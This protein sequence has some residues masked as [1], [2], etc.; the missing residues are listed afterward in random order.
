MLESPAGIL[1]H[2]RGS[3]FSLGPDSP[4]D[5]ASGKRPAHTLMPVTVTEGDRLAWVAGA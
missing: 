4:D 3:S 1:A 2:N 5:L